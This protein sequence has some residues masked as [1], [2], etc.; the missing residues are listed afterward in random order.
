MSLASRRRRKRREV[1]CVLPPLTKNTLDACRPLGRIP[2]VVALCCSDSV[3]ELPGWWR[4]RCRY[5][6]HVKVATQ[7]A[8]VPIW[9]HSV[10]RSNSRP[11]L[12]SSD[13]AIY[14]KP[15]CRTRFDEHGVCHAVPTKWNSLPDH[16]HQIS[17]TSLFKCH[18]KTELFRWEYRHWFC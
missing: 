11:G 16:L 14:A 12:G 7:E 3:D 6:H 17:F 18:L 1:A 8:T 4:R 5:T 9:P 10:S 13:T 2:G 15:R